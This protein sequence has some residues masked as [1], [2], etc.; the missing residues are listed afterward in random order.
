MH[1]QHSKPACLHSYIAFAVPLSAEAAELVD[2]EDRAAT[3]SLHAAGKHRRNA[4][5]PVWRVHGPLFPP[6]PAQEEVVTVRAPL[7]HAEQRAPVIEQP[8]RDSLTVFYVLHFF[9]GQRRDR[10]FQWWLEEMLAEAPLPV[11]TISVDVGIDPERCDLADP[12]RVAFWLEAAKAG[13]VLFV[14]GGPPCETWTVARWNDGARVD[15]EGPRAVRSQQ[16]LWG[17]GDLTSKEFGQ[18][19]LGNALLRTMLL[20][21][22]AAKVFHFA[23]VMEHPQEPFHQPQAPSVWRLPETRALCCDEEIMRVHLDQCT[24]GTP[25]RKPTC[26]LAVEAPELG[27]LVRDL[28]GGGRCNPGLGHEHVVMHGMAADGTYKTAPAKTYSSG[29]CHLLA[30]TALAAVQKRAVAHLGVSA[31][32]RLPPPELLSLCMHVDRYEPGDAGWTHDCAQHGKQ[33]GR[34]RKRLAKTLVRG[35]GVQAR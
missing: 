21:A 34:A 15:V 29:L 22:A 11:W 12:D 7:A 30:Q 1:L 10:D 31:A 3:R 9:S 24:T 16:M 6:A 26:L 28:P 19:D 5:L 4:A 2:A 20:F 8:V 23:A 32:E 17:L 14:L 13:K 27:R 25:W 35:S 33:P 18:V